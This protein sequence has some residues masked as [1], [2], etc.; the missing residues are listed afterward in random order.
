MG[1]GVDKRTLTKTVYELL[2]GTLSFEDV[3]C[4]SEAGK[5]DILPANREL[6]GAEVE[7]I[8][9]DYRDLRLKKALE[10]VL[11]KYD[12]VLIDCP[13]SLSM[14]T[15]NAFCSAEGVI[16]PMQCE[17]YALEG[18]SDL[19]STV[20]RIYTDKNRQLRLITLLR[21]MYDP[22]ITL[23]QQVSAQLEEHFGDKVFKTIIPRNVRLAEAPSYGLPG[24]IYDKSSKGAKAYIAC[25]EELIERMK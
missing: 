12:F 18:L 21:V 6:S 2:L 10:P 8:G 1:G 20:R 11:D 22:R 5:F 17:Y 3:V 24:V 16:I 15:I 23:Q 7:L 14:L 19:I 4:H 9:L 25:A 13:P